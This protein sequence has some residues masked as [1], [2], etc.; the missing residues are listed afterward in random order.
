MFLAEKLN[1]EG[2]G[3]ACTKAAGTAQKRPIFLRRH[4]AWEKLTRGGFGPSLHAVAAL[5]SIHIA[6]MS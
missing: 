4:S 5:A 1:A 2:C 3:G 6:N